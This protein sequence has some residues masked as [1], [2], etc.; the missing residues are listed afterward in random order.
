[1]STASVGPIV[2]VVYVIDA[3]GVQYAVVP[4]EVGA[5]A[6]VTATPPAE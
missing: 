4:D 2:T 3:E 1:M 5:L 6:L